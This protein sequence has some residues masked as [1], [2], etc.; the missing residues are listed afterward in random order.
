MARN[1][2]VNSINGTYAIGTNLLPIVQSTLSTFLSSAGITGT[3][4][5]QIVVLGIHGTSDVDINIKLSD[6]SQISSIPNLTSSAYVFEAGVYSDDIHVG[7]DILTISTTTTA[8]SATVKL[9]YY[10]EPVL[11]YNPSSLLA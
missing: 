1:L 7:I 5:P 3:G 9:N 4:L 6:F 8:T 2:N 11:K 10:Y